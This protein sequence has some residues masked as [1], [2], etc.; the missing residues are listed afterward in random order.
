MLR[1]VTAYSGFLQKKYIE[2]MK[3]AHLCF[4]GNFIDN[5]ISVFEH[6][7][8]GCNIWFIS[9]PRSGDS[10]KIKSE[11]DN[12]FWYN[13][14]INSSYINSIQDIVL[15]E[16]V[17]VIVLHGMARDF[18]RILQSLFKKKNYIV[19]WIFWG[20]ELYGALGESGKMK[21]VDNASPWNPLSYILPTKYRFLLWHCLIK[22]TPGCESLLVGTLP[23]IDYFC[24][25]LHED[26]LL[27]K[28]YYNTSIQFKYFQYGSV[29]RKD[30]KDE[31]SREKYFVKTSHTILLNHQ[32][33]TFGNHQTLMKKLRNMKG[34][35]DYEIIVPLSYG[36]RVVKKLVLWKGKQMFRKCFKP[37][38]DYMDL[39]S[40]QDI[41][42][43]AEV[44][45]FG[46]HRQEAVGNIAFL[47]ACGT[48]VFLREDNVLYAYFKKLGYM[49]FSYESDL[50]TIEDLNG[51]SLEQKKF[52][53]SVAASHKKCYED[54]MP[55]FFNNDI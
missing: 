53:A 16:K 9:E 55:S 44:A 46:H 28:K 37:I 18:L 33:S 5:A 41:I 11:G 36:S 25:W 38:L 34:I 17:E 48:K 24:F 49:V 27:L 54:F 50:H 14:Q 2:I 43:K 4:D 35:D 45:L 29:Y 20:F 30:F 51:L 23:Y 8:P 1:M 10:R 42:G 40:Y 52:N 19:Y 6:F 39:N 26:Y 22:R 7:C 13:P 15:R 47:L 32:A 12:I 31:N 3:A 21:L